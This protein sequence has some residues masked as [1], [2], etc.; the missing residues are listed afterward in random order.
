MGS[1][2]MEV[3][4]HSTVL[5]PQGL[6]SPLYTASQGGHTETVKLLVSRG[7]KIDKRCDVRLVVCTHQQCN[8][9]YMSCVLYYILLPQTKYGATP[10]IIACSENHRE[11]VEFLIDHGADVNLQTKVFICSHYF[12]HLLIC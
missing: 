1:S 6:V 3:M 10:L 5:S 9:L 12:H 8:T 7:A 11:V 4:C 2:F